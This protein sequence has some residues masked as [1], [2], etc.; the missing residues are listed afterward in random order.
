[1]ALARVQPVPRRVPGL[2][3]TANLRGGA[4]GRNSQSTASAPSPWPPF[5]YISTLRSGEGSTSG[6]PQGFDAGKKVTGRKRHIL[7]DPLGLLLIV[8]VHPAD[9]QDRDGAR[10]LLRTARRLFP[11]VKRIF[12]DGG[13]Q[14]TEDGRH[15]HAAKRDCMTSRPGT[16]ESTT[17]RSLLHHFLGHDPPAPDRAAASGA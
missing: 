7:V 10:E 1:M 17:R 13:Y 9:V 11:F 3:G 8:A 14:G 15:P 2:H 4:S 6:H 12:A 5:S 16:P